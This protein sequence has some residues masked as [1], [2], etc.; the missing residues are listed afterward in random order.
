MENLTTKEIKSLFATAMIT[1]YLKLRLKYSAE[2]STRM[3]KEHYNYVLELI[4]FNLT[5]I[6]QCKLCLKKDNIENML[7]HWGRDHDPS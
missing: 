2:K 5:D 6:V 1:T 7:L 3:T 4:Q